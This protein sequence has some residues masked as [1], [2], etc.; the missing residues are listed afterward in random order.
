MMWKDSR[1]TYL[2]VECKLGL[3]VQLMSPSGNRS[4][5]Q[6]ETAW[7]WGLNKIVAL[8]SNGGNMVREQHLQRGKDFLANELKVVDQRQAGDRVF[9]VSAKEVC[10]K[11][12]NWSGLFVC[13]VSILFVQLV[14][15]SLS[16]LLFVYPLFLLVCLFSVHCYVLPV[17]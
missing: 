6:I 15:T 13:C 8:A 7:F 12:L 3:P 2:T 4:C 10:P 5:P 9:F 11:T 16:V 17:C 14:L 1:V